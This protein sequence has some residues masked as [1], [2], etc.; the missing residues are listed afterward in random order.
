V[1]VVLSFA[2]L[3]V[4]AFCTASMLSTHGQ[5]PGH[6]AAL[7]KWMLRNDPQNLQ[8]KS[9][10]IWSCRTCGAFAFRKPSRS[11]EHDMNLFLIE[12]D[13]NQFLG[14]REPVAMALDPAKHPI[15]AKHFWREQVFEET[16]RSDQIRLQ[17]EPPE[18]GA[19]Q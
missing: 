11:K 10:A 2:E 1:V 12:T 13:I 18:T 6:L 7:P 16:L 4:V 17:S 9:A 15:L 5:M 8:R 3:V 19:A 14:R